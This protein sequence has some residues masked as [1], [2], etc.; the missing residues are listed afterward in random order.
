MGYVLHQTWS[1]LVVDYQCL[2]RHLETVEGSMPAVPLLEETEEK[3]TERIELYQV[4]Y[5]SW[6]MC[7][8]LV[9]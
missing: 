2:F 7:Q 6:Y 3:L 5:S 4:L 8:W 1:R 9:L